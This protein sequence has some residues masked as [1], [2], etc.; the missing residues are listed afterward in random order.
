MTDAENIYRSILLKISTIPAHYLQ[1]VD[2]YLQLV[3]QESMREKQ[4]NRKSIL[5][6]AGGWDDM[7]ESSFN[8][9]LDAAKNTG[10]DMFQD[11]DIIL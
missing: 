8:E 4:A 11:R 6:L 9:Y 10:K 5:A 1:Q 2:A 3:L 7:S